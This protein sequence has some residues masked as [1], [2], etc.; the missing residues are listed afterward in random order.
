MELFM[1]SEVVSELVGILDGDIPPGLIS[2]TC[3]F[4]NHYI[5]SI[6]V[7]TYLA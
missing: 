3:S 4:V 1:N 5:C 6:T 7:L 2:I